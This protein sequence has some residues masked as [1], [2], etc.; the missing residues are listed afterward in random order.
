[1]IKIIAVLCRLA[2]PADCH[3]VAVTNSDI[4]DLTMTACMVG[5]PALAE[6]MKQYPAHRLAGWKCSV[7]GSNGRAI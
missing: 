4:Q 3:E 5:V 7:G 1:M 2:A 6:W